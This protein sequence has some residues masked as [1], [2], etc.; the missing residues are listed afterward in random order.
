[1]NTDN[2]TKVQRNTI[3]RD[4]VLKAVR[5][6][7][8]PS[9]DDIFTRV[10]E[11]HPAI[12]RGT[13]YRN[14]AVLTENGLLRHITGNRGADRYDWDIR[15]HYHFQCRDCGLL[16]NVKLPYMPELTAHVE[17]ADPEF[18]YESHDIVFTGLCPDC[19]SKG[20]N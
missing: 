10:T 2:D 6:M 17:E 18:I 19:K 20:E 9:A 13:V 12:S 5:M 3:Q 1:M 7:N 14:L 11:E 4:A 16:F 15:P 8:H